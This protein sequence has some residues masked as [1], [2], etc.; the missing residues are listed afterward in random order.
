MP[1]IRFTILSAL[2]LAPTVFG[3]DHTIHRFEKIQ[4]SQHF[5]SE[6][7]AIGDFNHDGQKDVVSGPY[8]W[9]GPEFK[10][11][12]TYYPDHES[13]VLERPDG[14]KEIIPGYPGALS[15]RNAYS[16]NFLTYTYD[17]N[18]DGWDDILVLG[19]PGRES[20]WYENPRTE[21]R[22]WPGHVAIAV[23][24]NESPLLTDLTGD[25]RPEIVCNSGGYFGF[26]AP[27]WNVPTRPW[28]F[29]RISRK[30]NWQ[31]FTHGLGVGDVNGDGRRDLLEKDG[32]WEHPPSL[33]GDPVWQF[34]PVAF[35]PGG[36]SQMH[37]FDV[38]G[39]GDNDVITCL[40]AHG[41]GLA[42]YEHRRKGKEIE[43]E[44]HVFVNKEAH[45]NRYGVHFSQPH[46]IDIADMDRDGL[47]DIIT[48]KRF[49]AHGPTGDVEPNAPA[50]LYWFKLRRTQ[51]TVDW[52]PFQI[53]DDSGIG[54]QVMAQDLD[55]DG[56][57]EVI[58]G[59]KKGSFV[60]WNRPEKASQTAW[61]K[62]L[63]P[64]RH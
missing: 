51:G 47:P 20:T 62:S 48:G 55:N 19:F 59:N 50:V 64:V 1:P 7:A 2:C 15:G 26:A 52:I 34:H 3:A 31:R 17:F 57:P 16:D 30:G 25:G 35:A 40:T 41:Y 9:E 32:W 58:V 39:D 21:N 13:F 46:A 28:K 12:H 56:Y 18:G 38:D 22:L 8:W 53:D 49:W 61:E 54:T 33:D 37:A 14:S 29:R 6:G 42:W 4:L 36:S 24:D 5:W 60:H 43:F 63:P 10:R 44:A 45:E 27:D 23:T 11:R